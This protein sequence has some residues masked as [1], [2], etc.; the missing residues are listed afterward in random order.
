MPDEQEPTQGPFEAMSKFACGC[1]HMWDCR[2][3]W[4][5]EEWAQETCKAHGKPRIARYG[6]PPSAANKED[7]E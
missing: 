4:A 1:V 6:A 2:R 5:A 3:P 7:T